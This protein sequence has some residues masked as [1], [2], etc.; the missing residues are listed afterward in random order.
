MGRA[1][2]SL[3]PGVPLSTRLTQLDLLRATMSL[4]D[5]ARYLQ[6]P[7]SFLAFV[8]YKGPSS[9]RYTSFSIPKR[10]GGTRV[11]HAPDHHLKEL[12]QRLATRLELCKTEIANRR[13]FADKFSHGFEPGRSIITNAW[14]HKRRRFVLNLDL[15]EFFPSINFGACPWLLPEEPGFWVLHSGC[16]DHYRSNSVLP[17]RASARRS[18]VAGDRQLDRACVGCPPR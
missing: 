6:D 15:E 18:I 5:F 8:L 14:S 17:E 13:G 7:P 2:A 3:S 10:S 9:G 12:Q 1:P 11:I 4:S 16:R